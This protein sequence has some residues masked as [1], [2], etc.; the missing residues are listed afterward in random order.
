MLH[1]D[2]EKDYLR[3]RKAKNKKNGNYKYS[4]NNLILM[5]HEIFKK[6]FT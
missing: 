4:I 5:H 3:V 2:M 6:I 1:S